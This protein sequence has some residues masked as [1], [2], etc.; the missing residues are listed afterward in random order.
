MNATMRPIIRR[1]TVEIGDQKESA[2]WSTTQKLH[3]RRD[4][5]RRKHQHKQTDRQTNRNEQQTAAESGLTTTRH[6]WRVTRQTGREREREGSPE[7][8]PSETR[9]PQRGG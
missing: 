3:H 4:R 2:T 9:H 8:K 1:N 6:H 7:A 5:V